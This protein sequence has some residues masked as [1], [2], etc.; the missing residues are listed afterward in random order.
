MDELR[1]RITTHK[2]IMDCNVMILPETWLISGV[3]DSTIELAG[4]YILWADRTADDSGKSRGG[5]L[6][7]YVNSA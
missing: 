7:I 4:R 6:C 3:P 2:C 1:L 5:G